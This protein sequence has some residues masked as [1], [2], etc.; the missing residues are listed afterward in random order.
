MRAYKAFNHSRPIVSLQLLAPGV[1]I[2]THQ[3][4]SVEQWMHMEWGLEDLAL[5]L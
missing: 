2:L 5:G 1:C 4:L 3:Y